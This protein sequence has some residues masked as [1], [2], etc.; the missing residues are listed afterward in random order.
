MTKPAPRA[1]GPLDLKRSLLE[2]FAI[3][4]KTNQLILANVNDAAWQAPGPKG[5]GLTI[6][7]HGHPIPLKPTSVNGNGHPLERKRLLKMKAQPM[8][9]D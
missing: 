5:K 1:A 2:T 3:N 9:W 7:Q 4:E 6:R 8:L